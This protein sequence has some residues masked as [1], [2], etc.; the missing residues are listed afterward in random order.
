MIRASGEMLRFTT[1]DGL[2]MDGFLMPSPKPSA[3]VIHVHGM[4]GNFYGSDL[5]FAMASRLN[6]KGVSLFTINTRGHDIVSS[7]YQTRA[8][9]KRSRSKH[10]KLGT[11]LERFEDCRF[12][13]DGAIRELGKLGY[14]KFFLSGHSTG[15]QKITYYQYKSSNS[16]VKG[17][18]LL[19]PGSDYDAN[20]KNLGRRFNS[21]IDMCKRLVRQGKGKTLDVVP[22]GLSAK[23]FLSA[24]DLSNVE[25]RL[26]DYNGPLKEIRDIKA[27]VLAIFGSK[28]ESA[29]RP[30]KEYMEILERRRAGKPFSYSIIN[31]AKHSFKKHEDDV[32]E[33]ASCWITKQLGKA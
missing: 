22:S 3:C 6:K 19:A 4:T 18:I 10:L 12:D 29:L 20:K 24:V 21:T 25:A 30:V 14:K 13:I 11:S 8:R 23:R 31:G 7:I 16:N 5:Q 28:E 2:I 33:I 32:A 9:L 17:L 15:C 26:F 1:K 27:P